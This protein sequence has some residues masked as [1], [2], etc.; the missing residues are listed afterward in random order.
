ML[1]NIVDETA[2]APRCHTWRV[3]RAPVP[4]YAYTRAHD[5]RISCALPIIPW[6]IRF[7]PNCRACSAQIEFLL[8]KTDIGRLCVHP[9]F[10]HPTSL[11]ASIL[12]FP[13]YTLP[14]SQF[15]PFLPPFPPP[16]AFFLL[17]SNYF[18]LLPGPRSPFIRLTS[19]LVR[20]SIRT[21]LCIVFNEWHRCAL[22]WNIRHDND[23]KS[24]EISRE[25]LG[26]YSTMRIIFITYL[27]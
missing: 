26:N 16:S 1:W 23:E 24:L 20:A 8:I 2:G 6:I 25:K 4:D 7:S 14:H 9:P 5:A 21:F 12:D 22:N 10:P 11:A 19:T 18:Y 15:L 13:P 3:K 27:L 17:I